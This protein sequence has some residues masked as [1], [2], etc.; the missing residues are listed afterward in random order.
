MLE[1]ISVAETA[2]VTTGAIGSRIVIGK[3]S[4]EEVVKACLQRGDRTADR[5]LAHPR[6][7]MAGVRKK[8]GSTSWD[9]AWTSCR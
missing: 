2:A 5:A 8:S 1:M 7:R 4:A 3:C 6:S 9:L